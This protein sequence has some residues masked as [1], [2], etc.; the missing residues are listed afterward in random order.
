MSELR[1]MKLSS[2]QHPMVHP[3]PDMLLQGRMETHCLPPDLLRVTW[4]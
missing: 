1:H 4:L 2:P 3:R